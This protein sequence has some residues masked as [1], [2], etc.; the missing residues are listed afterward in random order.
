MSDFGKNYI[1]WCLIVIAVL[2]VAIAFEITRQRSPENK[3]RES[4]QRECQQFL[5]QCAR[6]R[7]LKDCRTDAAELWG[8]RY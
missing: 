4:S 6:Y 3:A 1:K 5:Y 7:P 8:C 2:T